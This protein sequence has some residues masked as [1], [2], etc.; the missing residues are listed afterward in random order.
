[1]LIEVCKKSL[2]VTELLLTKDCRYVFFLGSLY[3]SNHLVH[4]FVIVSA[5]ELSYLT[6]LCIS[7]LKQKM[8]SF[9]G[10]LHTSD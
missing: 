6:V 10:N 9:A 5:R 7:V 4:N 2:G 1:M 8:A 3:P